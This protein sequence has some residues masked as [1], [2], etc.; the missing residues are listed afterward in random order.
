MRPAAFLRSAVAA[1]ALAAVFG[2]RADDRAGGR[3]SYV[4]EDPAR[5]IAVV[6][7]HGGAG[8]AHG[9]W[10]NAEA[11]QNWPEMIAGDDAFRG[12]SIFV[13][14][15]ASPWFRKALSVPQLGVDMRTVLSDRG[16]LEHQALVFVAHSM[17]GL[18]VKE[19][20]LQFREYVDRTKFVFF[21]GVPSKGTELTR[22]ARYLT[23]NP[24]SRD[25]GS[26][27]IGS[28]LERQLLDWRT[29]RG[30]R[31]RFP[32]Y[33]AYETLP[34]PVYGAIVVDISSAIE[35][36][37][38]PPEAVVADHRQMVKPRSRDT[39]AYVMLREST[40]GS[41]LARIASS[42]AARAR[43]RPSTWRKGSRRRP[44]ATIAVRSRCTTSRSRPTTATSARTSGAARPTP[45]CGTPSARST[46]C[47]KRWR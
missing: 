45:R 6:F 7:V 8:S 17:G 13:Y 19:F 1:L 47:A 33:C 41:S 22:V 16:V 40:G 28:F 11:D 26:V 3:S 34:A 29:L 39:T 5:R 20:L 30:G 42:S 36:C 15:Y 9:T 27:E 46:T 18:V 43:S 2:V 4:Q 14:N 24:Q 38:E 12:A 44:R 21:F 37:F 10:K 31:P 35:G 23:D 32:V 25:V